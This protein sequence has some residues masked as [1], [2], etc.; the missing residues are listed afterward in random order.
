[1][2]VLYRFAF[3]RDSPLILHALEKENITLGGT[4]LR[5]VDNKLIQ[6][7]RSEKCFLVRDRIGCG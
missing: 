4:A 5:C 1:M 6:L 3:N 7:N 2:N